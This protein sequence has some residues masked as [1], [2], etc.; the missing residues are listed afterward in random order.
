MNY[1]GHNTNQEF[2][3]NTC[4]YKT[5]NTPEICRAS[6]INNANGNIIHWYSA[7]LQQ[8]PKFFWSN[9][10]SSMP[11]NIVMYYSCCLVVIALGDVVRL[12]IDR[13][14]SFT[15]DTIVHRWSPFSPITAP[16]KHHVHFRM[17][18]NSAQ[19]IVKDRNVIIPSVMWL[20]RYVV[21]VISLIIRLMP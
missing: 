7:Q 2:L 15:A 6:Y 3:K 18:I 8:I 14:S 17:Q 5:Y 20:D 16:H 1:H 12:L 10:I 21:G 9:I 4:T 13:K 19:H 11:C